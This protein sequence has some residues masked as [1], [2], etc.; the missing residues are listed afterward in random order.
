MLSDTVFRALLPSP[1]ALWT[2]SA[3]TKQ[4]AGGVGQ[5]KGIKDS[6]L[7]EMCVTLINNSLIWDGS[8]SSQGESQ[9]NPLLV[10][11][12]RE[13]IEQIKHRSNENVN[14]NMNARFFISDNSRE[15]SDFFP[16]WFG[17]L[18]Y[19]FPV[20]EVWLCQRSY[21]WIQVASFHTTHAQ[22]GFLFLFFT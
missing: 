1:L 12:W 8:E 5:N 10:W 13:Q 16:L 6:H 20:E 19:S 17:L 11:L 14:E 18:D 3:V 2:E 9:F 4:P 22:T 7:K 21:I 15:R